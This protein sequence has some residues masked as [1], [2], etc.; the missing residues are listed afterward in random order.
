M[1]EYLPYILN[2]VGGGVLG[3][4]I[5]RL[6]NGQMSVGALGG[7]IGGLA[8]G[9]GADTAGMASV[10]GNEGMMEMLQDLVEGVVGGGALGSLAGIFTTRK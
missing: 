2:A 10:I 5:S 8:A 6:L 9:F 4:I 1:E 7:V 3:P